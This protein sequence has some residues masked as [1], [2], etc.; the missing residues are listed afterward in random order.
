MFNTITW[1]T[2]LTTVILLAG[3]YYF[4]TTFLLYHNEIAAWFKS[5]SRQ[6]TL[7]TSYIPTD[8][9]NSE[10]ILGKIRSDDSATA[11][12]I[13]TI[14]TEDLSIG[15]TQDEEPEMVKPSTATGSSN[16]GLLIGNVAD[17]LQEIKTLIQLITEYKSDRTECESLFRTL[18]LRYPHLRKTSYRE[19]I[20]QYICETAKT[21]FSFNLHVKEVNAW[22]EEERTIK[23]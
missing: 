7:L 23:K 19:A 20:C 4:I 6:S 5:R 22:W 12:R 1:E 18:L 10:N 11:E 14:N 2:F 3:G 17:L 21:Q 13:S 16:D 9:A 8:V 15:S